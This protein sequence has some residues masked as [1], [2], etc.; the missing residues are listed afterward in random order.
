M[1]KFFSLFCPSTDPVS[2]ADPL[3]LFTRSRLPVDHVFYYRCPYHRLRFVLSICLAF[4]R[5]EDVY[6][7]A[8]TY[9]YSYTRTQE[10]LNFYEI[11]TSKSNEGR[12][13][14]GLTP[15]SGSRSPVARTARHPPAATASPYSSSARSSAST[16]LTGRMTPA[17]GGPSR[18]AKTLFPIFD[19]PSSS[20]FFRRERLAKTLVRMQFSSLFHSLQN[21]TEYFI[22]I[23]PFLASPMRVSESRGRGVMHE[24]R[25]GRRV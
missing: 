20:I 23:F 8:L 24:H 5:E 11:L 15:S 17:S 4:A 19:S 3:S 6:Q 7:V 18:A 14:F 1:H 16:S 13:Y 12:E 22:Q 10:R 25:S 21:W 2:A 9:P